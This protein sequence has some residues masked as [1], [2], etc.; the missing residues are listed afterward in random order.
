M[1]CYSLRVQGLGP[2]SVQPMPTVTH[3]TRVLEMAHQ[4]REI[5]CGR[6]TRSNASQGTRSNASQET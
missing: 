4:I 5:S 2:Q 6:W 1:A 3:F